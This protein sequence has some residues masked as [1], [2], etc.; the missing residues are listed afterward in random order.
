[1]EEGPVSTESMSDWEKKQKDRQKKREEAMAKMEKEAP[2][3]E[4]V[5]NMQKDTKEMKNEMNNDKSA[6]WDMVCEAQRA[7]RELFMEEDMTFSDTVDEL[8][9]ALQAIKSSISTDEPGAKT[10]KELAKE[11]GLT[12]D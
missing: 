11:A 3:N 1:M 7:A 6:Q 8:I 5:K 2:Q 4:V 10:N 12:N 9:G